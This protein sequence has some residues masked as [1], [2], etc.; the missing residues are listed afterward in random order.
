MKL[1]LV[2]FLFSVS[3]NL[4]A[5]DEERELRLVQELL[6]GFIDGEALFLKTDNN[7]SYLALYTKT[8]LI[9]KGA[10]IVIHG[11]GL[12]ANWHNVTQP[13]RTI[14]PEF[15]WDTLSLQMPVLEK[16]ALFDD[17][18]QVLPESATRIDKAVE[19][20]KTIGYKK[21]IIIAHSCG[22]QMMLQWL[23][24]QTNLT[25]KIDGLVNISLGIS[26]YKRMNGQHPPLNTIK[27]PI[28]DIY[29]S[30]DIVKN[31]ALTRWNL[32]RQ[33]G[34]KL[35]KQVEVKDADHMF[36]DKGEVLTREIHQWLLTL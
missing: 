7:K 20:L 4:L 34:H 11:R 26:N 3:L 1:L 27:I 23:K 5:S 9:S 2:I 14:L 15:G 29:G 21:I 30:E 19:T 24:N 16:D 13:I 31:L 25:K 18:V 17:Y 6:E 33:A 28:L 35:S 32:I 12:H 10:I 36:V 8:E 22:A